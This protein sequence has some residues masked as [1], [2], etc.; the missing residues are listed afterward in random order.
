M[1]IGDKMPDLLGTDSNGNEVRLSSYPGMNFIRS[2]E[3]TS[4]LQS[5]Y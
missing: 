5:P 4:E 1:N 3:H 2:E